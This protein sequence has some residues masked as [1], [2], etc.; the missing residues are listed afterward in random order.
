MKLR[1]NRQQPERLDPNT[2][3]TLI[4]EGSVFE[5]KIKSEAGVRIEGQITGDI[6]CE[7]DVTIGEKGLVHSNILARNIIIAGEV[8]GN[9]QAK[10]KLSITSKGKLYGNIV[11]TA[12]SVEEG[13]I[14]EGT[15]K[16]SGGD[17]AASAAVLSPGIKETAAAA[18]AANAGKNG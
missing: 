4:G 14:F 6:E 5:G 1:G 16:M 18:E 3:D 12:L 8:H 11:T 9:V 13:S 7:G 15:S 17:S 2:T 10:N